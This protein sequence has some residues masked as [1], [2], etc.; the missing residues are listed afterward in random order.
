LPDYFQ[1]SK[2][3]GIEQGQRASEKQKR[4]LRADFT[5]RDIKNG[6]SKKVVLFEDKRSGYETQAAQWKE[7]VKQLAKYLNFVC[8]EQEQEQGKPGI[9]YRAVCIG[10][11]VRFYYFDKDKE[12]WEYP[13]VETGKAYELMEDEETVD[14]ILKEFVAKTRTNVLEEPVNS[15]REGVGELPADSGF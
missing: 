3:Y 12:I 11:Y 8:E 15:H 13:S 7:A 1:R 4:R 14:G 10:T 6:K 5:V 2:L 9:L